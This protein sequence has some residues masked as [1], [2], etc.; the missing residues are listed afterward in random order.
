MLYELRNY[1]VKKGRMQ[2][3]VKLF[4]EQ[5]L[6]FQVSKG[7]VITGIW[8]A[9][10]DPN[11]FIWM[12]RFKNEAERKKLYDKVYETT[13]WKDVIQPQ[14]ARLL[15]IKSIKVTRLVPTAKSVAQ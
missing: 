12:R 11:T 4:H 14:V 8:T 15:D 10:K 5:I 9:E 7:M 6:P 13:E 3:W 1:T 2:A